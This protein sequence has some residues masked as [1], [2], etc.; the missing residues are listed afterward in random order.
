MKK[1]TKKRINVKRSNRHLEPLVIPPDTQ[2]EMRK[3][4]GELR[5][6]IQ[7]I[8][9]QLEDANRDETI[10][11]LKTHIGK[12]YKHDFGMRVVYVTGVDEESL[13]NWTITAGLIGEKNETPWLSFE[14]ES[15][16][17]KME[18]L[19]PA[20][21]KEFFYIFNKIKKCVGSV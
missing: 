21:R 12:Y 5:E 4:Q 10:K 6:E 16:I 14:T 3:R 1:T 18:K 8:E 20:T 2:L 15:N 11:K 13:R 17:Y 19:L 7:K 9:K